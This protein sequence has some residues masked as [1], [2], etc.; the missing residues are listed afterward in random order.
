MVNTNT[1]HVNS[2]SRVVHNEVLHLDQLSAHYALR[3]PI[4]L[5]IQ[6]TQVVGVIAANGIG[7]ST[8]LRLILGIEQ[9][10]TGVVRFHE[11]S[12]LGMS[13]I[14]RA[15]ALSYMPQKSNYANHWT[16]HELIQQILIKRI[17]GFV[18]QN[19]WK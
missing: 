6:S 8:L 1:T 17:N 2:V 13:A 19:T 3:T 11:Q 12:V 16:T 10:C 9:A 4:S 5:K 18:K 14:D 7:K 15:K